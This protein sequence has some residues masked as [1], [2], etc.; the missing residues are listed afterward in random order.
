MVSLNIGDKHSLASVFG[1]PAALDL[2]HC[3]LS[4]YKPIGQGG[5]ASGAPPA[6]FPAP[7]MN[8]AIAFSRSTP[9]ESTVES[10]AVKFHPS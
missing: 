8:D 3:M 9:F 6:A 7:G 4:L 10:M 2:R 1:P 5:A